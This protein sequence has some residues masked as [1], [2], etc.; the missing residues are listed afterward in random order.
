MKMTP[1]MVSQAFRL[2]YFPLWA[3]GPAPALALS[4]AGIPFIHDVPDWPS[5]KATTPFSKLPMLEIPDSEGTTTI[6]HELAILNYVGR[7][8]P[9]KMLGSNDRDFVISSQLMCEAED[10]YAKVGRLQPTTKVPVKCSV[11]ELQRLWAVT[12]KLS[13]HNRDQGL[14]ANLSLLE[15]FGALEGAGNGDGRLTSGGSTIGECKLFSTLRLL[16]LIEESVLDPYPCLNTFYTRF[17]EL[18]E[19]KIVTESG[20][21]HKYFVKGDGQ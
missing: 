16:H 1:G 15:R 17:G 19:T 12:P 7:M 13:D 6:T 11:E 9:S 4:H 10:I 20:K 5:L 8:H 21:F 14:H 18:S 2:T 3:K